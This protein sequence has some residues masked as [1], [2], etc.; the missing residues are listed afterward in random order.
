MNMLVKP[1]IWVSCIF[2]GWETRLHITCETDGGGRFWILYLKREV[3]RYPLSDSRDPRV[4]SREANS[5][6]AVTPAGHPGQEP[7]ALGITARQRAPWVSLQKRGDR[8]VHWCFMEG[9]TFK[10]VCWKLKDMVE[11]HWA[12][13]RNQ[14]KR[15]GGCFKVKKKDLEH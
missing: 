2:F 9:V 5:P 7:T 10:E 8:C 4:N 13:L 6:T 12:G 15:Q 14:L 3:Y 11:L 1:S